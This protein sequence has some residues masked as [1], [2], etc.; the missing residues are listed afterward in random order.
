M[1]ALSGLATAIDRFNETVGR[2]T[3]WLAVAMVLV[4]FTVVVMR[5]VFG[6]GSIMMQ[7]SVVYLH[8][9][10][11]LVGAGYTLYHNGHVR[12]DVFYREAKPRTKAWVD[13]L[14]NLF[15]LIPV[16]ILIAVY[17][18]PYVSQSWSVL[19]G[20]KETSGIQAVFLLKTIIV[21]FCSVVALQGLA[22]ALH[23]LT[24]LTGSPPADNPYT[25]E[26]S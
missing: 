15:F 16:C 3:G 11:F 19:E 6:V 1:Q 18:L 8:S 25:K 26:D 12:V 20:S 9:L 21:V 17:S 14:G 7:E 22:I 4:Q 10:L 5:Y 13:L 23:A 2:I 24:F